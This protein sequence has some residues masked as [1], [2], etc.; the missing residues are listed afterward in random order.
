[1]NKNK[2]KKL[3][4]SLAVALA[5]LLLIGGGTFAYLQSNTEDVVN[6][7]NANQVT[8]ELTETTGGDYNIIPGTTQEKDPTVTVNATVPA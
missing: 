5:A 2:K 3:T 8:V 6:T 7:F 4:T 1:M